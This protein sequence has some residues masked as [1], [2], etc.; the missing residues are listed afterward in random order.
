MQSEDGTRLYKL[1][2]GKYV[3]VY[4]PIPP[5][6]PIPT[7]NGAKEIS[8]FWLALAFLAATAGAA[9]FKTPDWFTAM[10]A[11]ATTNVAAYYF[12]EKKG[13]KK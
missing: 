7:P 13:G 10:L 2:A 9:Y 11:T 6:P 1:E 8:R 3:Q 5:I 4:P 12:G